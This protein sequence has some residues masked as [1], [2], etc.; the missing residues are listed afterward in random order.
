METKE[1]IKKIKE[2]KAHRTG[3]KNLKKAYLDYNKYVAEA[4]DSSIRYTE[5]VADNLSNTLAGVSTQGDIS[6]SEY[7]TEKIN[8]YKP[9][10]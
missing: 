7:L 6:Y 10:N 1:L 2:C 8:E 4:M 5:Y 3:W 9:R